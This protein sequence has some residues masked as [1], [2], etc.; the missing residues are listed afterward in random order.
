MLLYFFWR[1]FVAALLF[2][3]AAKYCAA[4]VLRSAS[5]SGVGVGVGTGVAVEIGLAVGIGTNPAVD[6]AD[7]ARRAA[8]PIEGAGETDDPQAATMTATS[9]GAATRRR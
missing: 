3:A 9:A 8:G 5:G 2:V 4:A 7:V 6:G 1:A